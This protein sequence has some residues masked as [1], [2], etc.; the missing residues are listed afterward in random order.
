MARGNPH[1]SPNPIM[2][3]ETIQEADQIVQ[4]LLEEN[5]S[6]KLPFLSRIGTKLLNIGIQKY[7][8]NMAKE[9]EMFSQ[10]LSLKQSFIVVVVIHVGV[11]AGIMWTSSNKTAHAKEEDKK[12]VG[13]DA[14]PMDAKPE[15]IP[16]PTP[17]PKPQDDWPKTKKPVITKPNPKYTKEYIV[18]KG[19]TITSISK[20]YKLNPTRLRILN[21]INGDKIY[22]GQTLKLL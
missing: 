20:K 13:V 6:N 19:D 21:K 17:I 9:K 16:S 8:D 7:Y 3:K 22:V 4:E 5:E 12:Y 14:V 10:S 15:P 11:L 2:N 1:P 18:K